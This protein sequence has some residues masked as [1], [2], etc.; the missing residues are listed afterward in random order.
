MD[1]NL[2]VPGLNIADS[3]RVRPAPAQTRQERPETNHTPVRVASTPSLGEMARVQQ[4]PPPSVDILNAHPTI[5]TATTQ[6]LL[7]MDIPIPFGDA[8][9]SEPVISRYINNVNEALEPSFFRLNF[10]IHEATNRVMVTVIDT[11][12][13]EVLREIPPESR[14]DVVA[15]MQEF[16]GLLFDGKG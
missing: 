8:E 16:A 1:A 13:D 7:T 6:E 3:N 14:L 5:S 2:R 15:R 11:N 4:A 10:N 12:T 9:V